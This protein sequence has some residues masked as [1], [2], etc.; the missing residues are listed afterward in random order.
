MTFLEENSIFEGVFKENSMFLPPRKILPSPG[1]KS[2]D[3]H[4]EGEWRMK[5]MNQYPL[6][7]LILKDSVQSIQYLV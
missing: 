4:G 3:A 6:G 1:K 7:E 5:V 2:A